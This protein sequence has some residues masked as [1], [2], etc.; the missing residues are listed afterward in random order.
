M[1]IKNKFDQFYAWVINQGI[2]ISDKTNPYQCFDLAYSWVFFLN[3]PKATIQHLYAYEVFTAPTATTLQYFDLIPNTATFI[4]QVGDLAVFDKTAANIAGHISICNG[5]GDLI[6]FQ[7]I[8]QNWAGLTRATTVNHNYDSPKL[9]G[10]LRPKL[11]SEPAP[12][13]NIDFGGQS[14]ELETYGIISK[15]TLWSK[16][17]AKDHYIKTHP[18]IPLPI[19]TKPK[20]IL[21][22]SLAIEF[23]KE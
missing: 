15:D 6:N 19:F 4:P 7:S 22:N 12:V 16:L 14:T 1:T 3:F 5:I 17:V 11:I 8:D 21:F 10:V 23:E 20:S 9:L 18:D 2:E 13:T